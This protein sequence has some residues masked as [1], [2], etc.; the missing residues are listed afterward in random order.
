MFGMAGKNDAIYS[1]KKVGKEKRKSG[2]KYGRGAVK[3]GGNVLA[4]VA[5]LALHWCSTGDRRQ[6]GNLTSVF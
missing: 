2:K 4:S 5:A 1:R 6:R 3:M